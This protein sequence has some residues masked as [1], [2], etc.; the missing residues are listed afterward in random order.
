ML[1]QKHI[2]LNRWTDKDSNNKT[3]LYN[4]TVIKKKEK[5]KKMSRYNYEM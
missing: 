1:V 4:V 5:K 3:V 2:L